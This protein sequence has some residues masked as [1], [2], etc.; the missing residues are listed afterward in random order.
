MIYALD[1]TALLCW[2]YYARKEKVQDADG[3]EIAALLGLR[4][5][6]GEFAERLKPEYCVAAID[7]GS[8]RKQIYPEYKAQRKEKEEDL[9]SQLRKLDGVFESEGVPVLKCKDYEGDDILASI[10]AVHDD[11]PVCVVS[12]DK[13]L[14]QLVGDNVAFFDPIEGKARDAEGVKEKFGVTPR[15]L[16]DFLALRGDASDNIPGVDGIGDVAASAVVNATRSYAEI[17]RRAKDGT[18]PLKDKQ[19]AK[20]LEQLDVLELSRK[21]VD[22]RYDAPTVPHD[23][24]QLRWRKPTKEAA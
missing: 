17:V 24:E 23:L 15:R 20:I 9:I 3:N 7:C 12:R 10:V 16:R 13:D 11:K 6:L 5:W 21:L 22:L 1:G 4:E 18:L 2:Q 14:M 8:F 19:K